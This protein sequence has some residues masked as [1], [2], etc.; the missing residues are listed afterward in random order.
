MKNCSTLNSNNIKTS[1][2]MFIGN[3]EVRNKLL[4]L[5]KKNNY[6]PIIT[7]DPEQLIKKIRGKR[8]AIVFVDHEVVTNYG[9]RI[10]SR[11]NVACSGCDVLL[12][13]DVEGL[14][15]EEAAKVLKCNPLTVSTWLRRA[16]EKLHTDLERYGYN[17]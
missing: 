2:L 14:S 10:Y 4:E 15:Y 7:T 3:E 11:I 5:C 6:Y 12:L 13:C 9:A 1:I 8:S 17:F 16:R